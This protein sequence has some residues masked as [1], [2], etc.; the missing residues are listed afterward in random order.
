MGINIIAYES[1]ERYYSAL[2]VITPC[3]TQ[4]TN[5]QKVPLP[6]CLLI[7]VQKTRLGLERNTI[8]SPEK[9]AVPPLKNDV[10]KTTFHSF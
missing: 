8:Y 3:M 6:F 4:T 9:L 2:W 5:R 7:R 1:Y 10:W